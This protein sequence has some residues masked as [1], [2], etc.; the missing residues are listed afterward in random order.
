MCTGLAFS[1]A[2]TL[3]HLRFRTPLSLAIWPNLCSFVTSNLRITTQ[4]RCHSCS[5]SGWRCLSGTARRADHIPDMR[6]DR[7]VCTIQS[8]C[9]RRSPVRFLFVL[10][11][12]ISA[13]TA[14]SLTV[15]G[16]AVFW[17]SSTQQLLELAMSI[18]FIYISAA[19]CDKV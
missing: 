17:R 9:M 8:R 10:G 15:S 16:T 14:L 6:R 18:V 13:H 2:S 19:P 3:P 7:A 5:P 4:A 11:V 12:N 1:Y